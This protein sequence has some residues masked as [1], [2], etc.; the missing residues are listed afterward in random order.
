MDVEIRGMDEEGVA[1]ALAWAEREGWQ[2]GLGDHLP[3]FAADPRGFFHLV[4]GGRTLATISVV[5]GSDS[6]AFVG[7]YIVDPDF[8]GQGFGK[9][10]WD[11]ALEGFGGFTL[12]LDA[13]PE[14]VDTYASD[15]FVSAYGNA[16]YS[17]DAG[18]LPDPEGSIRIEPVSAVPFDQVVAF[19]AAHFF[20]PRP[21][22]LRPWI[23][24]EGRR[25][26]VATDQGQITGFAASRPTATGHRLGPVFA[27]DSGIARELILTLSAELPGSVAIDLF[28]S[29]NPALDLVESLGMDRSFQTTRMYRGTPPELPIERIF[30]ITSLELG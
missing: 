18:T 16:R 30:G 13:V 28:L 7:L 11:R 14:Q 29:N 9:A 26:V 21:D 3:L 6:F 8:R 5:R 20:S 17:T 19:D 2:P 25:A 12:G 1:E 4:G 22:F 27:Q 15:G 24:G 23:G 10:L